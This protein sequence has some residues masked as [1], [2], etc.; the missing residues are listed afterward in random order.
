MAVAE[1]LVDKSVRARMHQASV[2][3]AVVPLVE[4]GLLA[5]CWMV[6]LEVLY[7]ARSGQQHVEVRLQRRG[8]DWVRLF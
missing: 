2:C 8:L 5:T 1:Y 7:S 4:R 3:E 6:D